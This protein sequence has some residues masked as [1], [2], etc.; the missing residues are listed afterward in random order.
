[1]I[2]L[3]GSTVTKETAL[4]PYNNRGTYYGDGVF[5]T[6]RC[7]QGKPLLFEAHYFRLMSSMRILRMD[8]PDTFTPEYI[9][10]QIKSLLDA[11]D[12]L[13]GHARIRMTVWRNQGGFYTP[14]DRGVQF[15]IEATLLEGGFSNVQNSEVELFKDHQICAGLLSNLK[16]TQKLVNILAGIYAE[17]NDYQ[18]MLLINQNKMVVESISG[19]LFLRSGNVIK[20]PPLADGCLN[21][22]MREQVMAQLK[23][24]LNYTVEEATITPFELQRADEMFTT[25]MIRGVQSIHKYR[26]KSFATA[27]ADELIEIF[28]DRLFS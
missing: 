10:E 12:L 24:M 21:G 9:E 13:E 8:I 16:S 14:A 17:E 3:N 20:T 23:M 4:I 19:N 15:V 22:I 5:E 6:L 18:D 11:N 1:M 27:C 25:N 7:F 26:K 28:N 2:I